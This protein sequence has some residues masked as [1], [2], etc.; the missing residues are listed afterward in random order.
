[1]LP[2]SSS[3][4]PRPTL[5]LRVSALSPLSRSS[6]QSAAARVPSSLMT[7]NVSTPSETTH[8]FLPAP[9]LN[10]SV[11][12]GSICSFAHEV[13]PLSSRSKI[14]TS[15]FWMT[16][17][18]LG[19]GAALPRQVAGSDQGPP[20]VPLLETSAARAVPHARS[21]QAVNAKQVRR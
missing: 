12:F 1:A 4:P 18:S 17:S 7:P 5:S 2:Y 15:C 14:T 13:L 20:P 21:R 10:S 19:P 9:V 11:P 8:T 6:S 16:T 3:P